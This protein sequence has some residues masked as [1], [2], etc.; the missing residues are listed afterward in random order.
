MFVRNMMKLDSGQVHTIRVTQT[1][2]TWVSNVTWCWCIM[3]IISIR[4]IAS[5]LYGMIELKCSSTTANGPDTIDLKHMS[6]NHHNFL[7]LQNHFKFKKFNQAMKACYCNCKMA[8][9]FKPF[10]RWLKTFCRASLI[11]HAYV[12]RKMSR[13][14][15]DN[16]QIF[17]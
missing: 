5:K 17:Y 10:L 4:P 16:L 13:R 1:R 7:C 15:C 11:I 14:G 2:I 8:P 12:C 9:N 3:R 6:R